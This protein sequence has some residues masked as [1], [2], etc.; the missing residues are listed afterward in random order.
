M[1]LPTIG[2][3]GVERMGKNMARRLKEVGYPIVAVYDARPSGF[4][5]VMPAFGLGHSAALNSR[6]ERGLKVS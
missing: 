6:R 5:K 3:V 4:A 2:F 1:S